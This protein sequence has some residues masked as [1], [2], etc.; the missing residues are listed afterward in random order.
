M[1]GRPGPLVLV[2]GFG[3][4]PGVAFNVSSALVDDLAS[5]TATIPAQ[6]HTISL[7]THWRDGPAMVAAKLNGLKPDAIVHFGVSRQAAGFQFETIA[8]NHCARIADCAG[9][10]AAGFYIRRGGPP[11]LTATLPI[12]AMMQRLRL[13][14]L[15]ASLSKDAGRYLCNATLFNSLYQAQRL[16]G[17]AR[18]PVGFVHIPALPRGALGDTD[19]A[20]GWPELRK[21]A[22]EIL[23]AL[24]QS[25]RSPALTTGRQR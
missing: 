1:S 9:N 18:P 7:P 21:G 14:G 15:P 24:I 17:H 8:Y 19:L 20:F 23:R 22:A 11:Y 2:T 3:P 5:R 16:P 10:S 25:L 4:F 13:A 12:K 6:L